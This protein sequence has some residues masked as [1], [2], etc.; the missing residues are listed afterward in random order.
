MIVYETASGT[1]YTTQALGGK[2]WADLEK[3]WDEDTQGKFPGTHLF[4]DWL[5]EA[6]N[7]GVVKQREVID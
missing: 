5:I 2:Y 7:T 4:K 3:E 6:I 1:L